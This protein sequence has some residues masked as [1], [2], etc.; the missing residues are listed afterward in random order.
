[1][2]VTDLDAQGERGQRAHP[3]QARQ[4]PHHR[5]K[6]RVGGH[7]R[8]LL[9]ERVAAKAGAKDR[10]VVVLEGRPGAGMLEALAPQPGLVA[11]RPGPAL[12]EHPAVAQQQLRQPVAGPHQIG[13]GV[14]AGAHQIAGGLIVPDRAPSPR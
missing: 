2:P 4:A 12:L 11:R 8:D 14:L 1:M 3:A 5:R 9:I 7:L 10:A 6:A 13:A